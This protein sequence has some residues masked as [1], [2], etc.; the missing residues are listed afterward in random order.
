MSFQSLVFYRYI[1]GIKLASPVILIKENIIDRNK[2][3]SANPRKPIY[4]AFSRPKQLKARNNI[5]GSAQMHNKAFSAQYVRWDAW[6]HNCLKTISSY[7]QKYYK[8]YQLESSSTVCDHSKF[9]DGIE[10]IPHQFVLHWGLPTSFELHW[11][12]AGTSSFGNGTG[13]KL[14][15]N[16]RTL[17]MLNWYK[18]ANETS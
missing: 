2:N 7:K 5:T 8:I 1:H 13:L 11:S 14:A 9:Y 12:Q 10:W 15:L 3:S 18:R 17:Y 6:N 4:L 16:K